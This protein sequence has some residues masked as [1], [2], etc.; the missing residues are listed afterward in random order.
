[1]P[2]TAGVETRI[3]DLD[4]S[5]G[6]LMAPPGHLF[7]ATDS[8][9]LYVATETVTSVFGVTTAADALTLING[10]DFFRA[11]LAM[12]SA[13][14]LF[15]ARKFRDGGGV[16]V[17]PSASGSVY[18]QVVTANTP[19][20]LTP[21]GLSW[22]G[23]EGDLAI[24]GNDNLFVNQWYSTSQPN[25]VYVVPKTTGLL[26]GQAV[27]ANT[28]TRVNAFDL[29]G[30][31]QAAGIDVDNSGNVFVSQYFAQI[32]VLSPMTR[33]VLGQQVVANIAEPVEGSAGALRTAQGVAVVPD[34]SSLISGAFLSTVRL[35][36]VAAPSIFT[37]S[38][39]SGP[40]DGGTMVTITGSDLAGTTNITFGG[41]PAADFTVVSSTTLI[42]IAPTH[43]VGTVDVAVTTPGGTTVLPDAF[44]YR[45][46]QPP[47]EA[48]GLASD[49]TAQ[50]G[51]GQAT[52]SW[53]APWFPGSDP[54]SR[55]VVTASPGGQ[56]CEVSVP[57]TTPPTIPATSCTVGGLTNG[58]AYTFT[59]R[60]GSVAGLGL[61]SNP[62]APATP[63]AVTPTPTPTPPP[64]PSPSP[65]PTP[66]SLLVSGTREGRLV[67]VSGTA[68]GLSAGARVTA[69]ARTAPTR[70]FR[71]GL[72]VEVTS[73]GAFTWSRQVGRANTLWVYF[74]AGGE[75]S[76][77]L[78][79]APR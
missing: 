53:V 20:L 60:A 69:H 28:L 36:P 38:P 6:I 70:A 49:V 5:Q 54:V 14:N 4:G 9:S 52:V 47:G 58:V 24:D 79:F 71:E 74:V 73:S 61:P 62:S 23:W 48:P 68:L 12:D 63:V 27:T 35:A 17:M 77:V 13:G 25:G 67:T 45:I 30:P 18:G 16:A 3:F 44:T 21:A 51:N 65:T 75:A 8:G 26:F 37:V 22:G 46:A 2:V 43:P 1:M 42:A 78:E 39:S 64:S 10:G 32:W 31:F 29:A 66:V 11:G 72:G 34:G 59:V 56:F 76:D 40:P 7:V 15:S 33:S 19:A 41:V 50:A 57:Y 55:Y